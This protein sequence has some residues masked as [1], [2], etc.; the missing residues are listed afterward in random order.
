MSHLSDFATSTLNTWEQFIV[1]T[2]AVTPRREYWRPGSAQL[3]SQPGEPHSVAKLGCL[4]GPVTEDSTRQR[5]WCGPLG[6]RAVDTSDSAKTRQQS[7]YGSDAI[8]LFR[9]R[10][11]LPTR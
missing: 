11:V 2:R 3:K 6:W 5:V 4:S 10:P 7:Y 1:G 8:D 9:A